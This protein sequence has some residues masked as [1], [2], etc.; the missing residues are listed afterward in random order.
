[1]FLN[2]NTDVSGA[3]ITQFYGV[4]IEDLAVFVLCFK[5]LFDKFDENLTNVSFNIWE[6][7]WIESNKFSISI[8]SNFGV[9]IIMAG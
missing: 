1:M 2:N 8:S 7:R 5:V 6:G 4:R 3:T 9:T